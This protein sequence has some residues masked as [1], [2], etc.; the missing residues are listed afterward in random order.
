MAPR[1]AACGRA[2]L[3]MLYGFLNSGFRAQATHQQRRLPQCREGLHAVVHQELAREVVHHIG[4]LDDQHRP[5]HG[6]Q[7]R[8]PGGF[9]AARLRCRA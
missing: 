6:V 5:P 2:H 3:E 8:V 9:G 7:V 1:G 4:Q